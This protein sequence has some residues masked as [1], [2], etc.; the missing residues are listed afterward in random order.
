MVLGEGEARQC[1]ANAPRFRGGGG[2]TQAD[3]CIK[4]NTVEPLLLGH[5]YLRDTL[6]TKFGSG[7][8]CIFY[9]YL[10]PTGD[11][12]INQVESP[13]KGYYLSTQNV[14]DH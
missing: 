14:T 8:M 13:F 3:Y 4:M 5:P 7:K 6:G 10:L 11:E 2:C 9:L 1:T 12:N